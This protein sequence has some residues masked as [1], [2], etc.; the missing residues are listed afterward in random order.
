MRRRRRTT[1]A[2]K[3]RGRLRRFSLPLTAAGGALLAYFFDPEQGRRRRAVARDRTAA[4]ARR[5]ARR[6]SQRA[7]YAE[8]QVRGVA[9]ELAPEPSKQDYDDTT[10]KHKIESEVLRNYDKGQVNVNVD[11]GVAVL[12]GELRRP[13]DIKKLERD[14][15]RVPGVAAVENLLHTP[16]PS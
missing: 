3:I 14:V 4:G 15:E 5:I 12:R 2:A 7:R 9:H 13:Q 16:G 11:H 10:L 1:R 6:T 8:G